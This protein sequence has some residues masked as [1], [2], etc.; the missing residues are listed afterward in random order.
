MVNNRKLF[1]L[2]T[3]FGGV[4]CT[5]LLSPFFINESFSHDT[6]TSDSLSGDSAP[7]DPVKAVWVGEYDS[8]KAE[9]SNEVVLQLTNTTEESVV[10]T[11]SFVYAGALN[12]DIEVEDDFIELKP[13]EELQR[14]IMAKDF[15]LQS[16]Q[17]SSSIIAHLFVELG[18]RTR[19][20]FSKPLY[21][22]FTPNYKEALLYGSDALIK[23]FNGG[24][25]GGDM[26]N[27]LLMIKDDKDSYKE[28]FSSALANEQSKKPR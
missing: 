12:K 14:S 27:P 13:G 23:T 18:D 21:Y 2:N 26:T 17:T 22:H 20:Y 1:K 28:Q 16:Y 9:R 11:L 6:F 10:V 19:D 5:I 24:F 4:L 8:V 25:I 3:I 7:L 15:S